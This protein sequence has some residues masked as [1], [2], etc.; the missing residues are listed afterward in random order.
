MRRDKDSLV[1][2][3][4]GVGP[5][6]GPGA[7]FFTNT[8]NN[9]LGDLGSKTLPPQPS[10]AVYRAGSTYEMKWGMR[11]NHGGEIFLLYFGPL[12]S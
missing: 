5:S 6:F 12:T 3:G 1:R 7:A 4:G 2:A 9:K 10:G 8:T 11:A